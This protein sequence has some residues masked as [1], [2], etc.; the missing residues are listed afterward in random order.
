MMISLR[1]RC[2]LIAAVVL[3][4]AFCLAP[5][6]SQAGFI[7]LDLSFDDVAVGQS[8]PTTKPNI[9][10]FP[11]ER[12]YA[13]YGMPVGGNYQGTTNVISGNGLSHAVLMSTNQAGMGANVIDTKFYVEASRISLDFD[14]Q[15]MAQ[16]ASGYAQATAGAPGGL[17][18][19]INAYALDFDP[20]FRFGVTPTADG[21]F[22]GLRDDRLGSKELNQFV[23]YKVGTDYHVSILADYYTN[24]VSATVSWDGLSASLFD[25]PFL[26]SQPTNGGMSQFFIY[27]NGIAGKSNEVALDNIVGAVVAPEPSTLA[28]FAIGAVCCAGFARRRSSSPVAV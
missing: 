23:G 21:G 22:F 9:D 11:I 15:I 17:L 8:I 4:L 19:A 26:S 27:Q 7:F 5:G 12:A 10:P 13:T 3:G 25:I 24:T 28:I 20:V 2:A 14:I 16:Q 1:S 6:T 18:F